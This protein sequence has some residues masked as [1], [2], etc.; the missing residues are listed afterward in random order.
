MASEA[1]LYTFSPETTAQL[2]KFKLSTSRDSKPKA[3]IYVIDKNTLEI[4]QEGGETFTSLE[5]LSGELPENSPRFVLLSH[6]VVLKSGRAST[7]YVMLYYMPVTADHKMRM[8]YAGAKELFRNTAD[9]SKI[10]DVVDEDEV[11]AVEETLVAG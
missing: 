2:R 5:E 8:I 3:R 4:K 11:A 10:L 7:P 9:A 1:R 6:P